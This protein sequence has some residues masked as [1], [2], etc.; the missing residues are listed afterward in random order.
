GPRSDS[1]AVSS[2][3]N[4]R[5]TMRTTQQ[6]SSL[7][8]LALLFIAAAAASGCSKTGKSASS[9]THDSASTTSA[10]AT[11]PSAGPTD[12]TPVHGTIA[13]V[14][15]SVLTVS[16]ASGDVRVSIAAPLDLYASAPAA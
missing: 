4:P 6:L 3:A 7:T 12:I 15:D 9:A 16:T 10:S 14:T 1:R 5:C 11:S 13:S 2:T 8:A